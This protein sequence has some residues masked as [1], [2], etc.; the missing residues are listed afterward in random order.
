ML[1]KPAHVLL[2]DGLLAGRMAELF[3]ELLHLQGALG[4]ER[5]V[6][7]HL[8]KNNDLAPAVAKLERVA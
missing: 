7:K 3:G 4:L 2:G 5:L 6:L 1:S 8:H